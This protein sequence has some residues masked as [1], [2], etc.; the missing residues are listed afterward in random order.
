MEAGPR[1]T[2]VQAKW[3]VKHGGSASIPEQRRY[4]H[5]IGGGSETKQV[6]LEGLVG[7]AG[8]QGLAAAEDHNSVEGL[9]CPVPEFFIGRAQHPGREWREGKQTAEAGLRRVKGNRNKELKTKGCLGSSDVL[10][11]S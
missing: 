1:G 8:W 7:R 5:P 6:P 9:I 4:G 11:R 3:Q 2:R 10:L